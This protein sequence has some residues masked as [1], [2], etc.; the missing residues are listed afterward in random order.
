MSRPFTKSLWFLIFGLSVSFALSSGTGLNAQETDNDSAKTASDSE[1][2]RYPDTKENKEVPGNNA[3]EARPVSP[4]RKEALKR[5]AGEKVGGEPRG[6]A[7]VLGMHIQ[8]ADNER[9]KVVEVA[10]ASAAFDAGIRKGDEIVSFDGFKATKYREWI[11]G[12]QRLATDAPDG[13]A[14]PIVIVRGDKRLNLRVRMPIASARAMPP[15]DTAIAQPIDPGQPQP[16]VVVP[17]QQP[18]PYG[19]GGGDDVM[20]A[21]AFGDDFGG[22][23]GGSTERAIAEIHRLN[24]P[25][26]PP[27]DNDATN[28]ADAAPASAT[29]SS[30][31]PRDQSVRANPN[32]GS[33]GP[34]IGLAGF[35]NDANGM[36]VMLDVG[37]LPPGNYIVGID[38]PS[39]LGAGGNPNRTL[40]NDIPRNA[41]RAIPSFKPPNTNAQ[42]GVQQPIVPRR[43]GAGSVQPSGGATPAGKPAQ[44]PAGA[45]PQSR[46][47]SPANKQV[48]IPRT[49]LAQVADSQA[50]TDVP[51]T[52]QNQPLD[53]PPTGN[54]QPLDTPPTGQVRPSGATATGLSKAGD[55]RDDPSFVN[56]PGYESG[57]SGGGVGPSLQIGILTVDQS[58]TGRLQQVV[59]SVRVQDVVGMAIAIYSQNATPQATLPPNL[60]AT[61]DP[62]SGDQ[63]LAAAARAKVANGAE[64][65]RQ[66][67]AS[68]VEGS[69]AN[70]ANG[71]QGM[72]GAVAA[73]LIRLMS[74]RL[75]AGSG[76]SPTGQ[77]LPNPQAPVDAQGA[78]QNGVPQSSSVPTKPVQQ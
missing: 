62:L 43:G 14:L 36:F 18:L 73:G 16:G 22:S 50:G 3:I 52:G 29:N 63:K 59:E 23:E 78:P 42:P 77:D 28:P 57:S 1:V 61:T 13:D 26:Q 31:S 54:T 17:G 12:M 75:P 37:G 39:V 30:S 4:A 5:R 71:A 51:A 24:T 9:A 55:P 60:D 10:P 40:P 11:D 68:D 19:G 74:D 47:Q 49:V 33:G 25:D 58:G 41:R 2:I 65:A 76:A 6:R 69:T 64:A 35:R 67:P 48:E 21:N 20:I 38:D 56:N 66:V 72:N 32:D 53:T 27:V 34:A 46:L 7:V 8:E 45:N 44:R 70:P 15:E